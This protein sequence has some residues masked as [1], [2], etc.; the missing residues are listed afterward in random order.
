MMDSEEYQAGVQRDGAPARILLGRNLDEFEFAAQSGSSSVKSA[1]PAPTAVVDGDGA[2]FSGD[3]PVHEL[4]VHMTD[5]LG[6]SNGVFARIN[7]SNWQS[8]SYL[9][10]GYT[11][12]NG[13][14]RHIKVVHM[15]QDTWLDLAMCTSDISYK[16]QNHWEA[17]APEAVND[18]R[19]FVKGS[20]GSPGARIDI[21]DAGRFR[22]NGYQVTA[23][24]HQ[25]TETH[26]KIISLLSDYLTDRNPH[27]LRDAEGYLDRGTFPILPGEQL[28]WPTDEPVPPSVASNPTYRYS[29]H[30][31]YGAAY[32]AIASKQLGDPR[33]INAARSLVEAW[34]QRSYYLV[35]Q[36]PRYAWYDHGTAERLIALLLIRGDSNSSNAS[37]RFINQLNHMIVAHG[38][39]LESESFYAANQVTRYHNHAWFQ[40]LALLAAG[41]LAP[42]E[43]GKR[44]IDL[45]RRRLKDQMA[46]L[47]S[48]DTDYAVFVENSTGYHSGVQAIVRFAAELFDIAAE[49]DSLTTVAEALARW[50]TRV[51]YPDRRTPSTGDSFRIPNSIPPRRESPTE[52]T[53]RVT[54]LTEAGIAVADGL[55]LD[56]PFAIRY[57]ATSMSRTHKHADN[58]SFTLYLD[59]VEWLIDPSFYSHEYLDPIPSYLRGPYSHN[60]MFVRDREYSIAPGLAR[61]TEHSINKDSFRVHG[62]H[63]AYRGTVIDRVLEASLDKLHIQGSDTIA[64]TDP[65][66]AGISFHLGEDV[67]A[68]IENGIALL[69]HPA[70]DLQLR[71]TVDRDIYK[72]AGWNGDATTSSISGTGFRA[73]TDTETLRA[74]IDGGRR[75]AWSIDVAK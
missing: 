37:A 71:I 46:R 25:G 74:N 24:E 13:S 23:S 16:V 31:L 11:G 60:V 45:S 47:I 21:Q 53:D 66:E 36:D 35:D 42:T 61:I 59:G 58:L 75:I 14:F 39:L 17:V 6:P 18:I 9:A 26:E 38:F 55:H 28:D 72:I 65:V 50:A 29:W 54:V 64:S 63:H 3:A 40:D 68:T 12:A 30:S 15:Q 22:S 56:M 27:I 73:Y 43:A 49:D 2:I 10:F 51:Q 41:V 44:W 67:T 32:L 34:A 19:V 70:S 7:I 57:F 48:H 5:A 8:V 33:G 52:P 4:R 62:R 1:T 20:P 69:H